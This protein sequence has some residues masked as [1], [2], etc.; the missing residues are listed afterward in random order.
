MK[1][2]NTWD[3][4]KFFREYSA[5]E[6]KQIIAGILFEY[7]NYR[8][9]VPAESQTFFMTDFLINHVSLYPLYKPCLLRWSFEKFNDPKNSNISA[10]LLVD[11][12]KSGYR[13]H[14]YQ[15]II[16]DWQN[17]QT[18]QIPAES[19]T[20]KNLEAMEQAWAKC[21]ESVKSDSVNL[22]DWFWIL[23]YKYLANVL[24]YRPEQSIID[25]A[26]CEAI[27]LAYADKKRE[28]EELILSGRSDQARMSNRELEDQAF[29]NGDKVANYRRKLIAVD[30]IKTKK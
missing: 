4:E 15:G 21:I 7:L 1:S 10:S 16:N 23:G 29:A 27:K 8:N 11:M 17:K 9:I 25:S 13:S 18:N 6:V 24:K 2:L 26:Q 5:D 28:S 12:I 30:Y 19:V 22:N 14:E 3:R 20:T